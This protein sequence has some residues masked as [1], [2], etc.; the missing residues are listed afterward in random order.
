MPAGSDV[1]ELVRD[2][3]ML[4][5]GI[6]GNGAESGRKADLSA[7]AVPAD[8]LARPEGKS[9]GKAVKTRHTPS[10]RKAINAMCKSCIYDSSN[11]GGTW[12][13][14]VEACAVTR[15]ALYEVRPVSSSREPGE[16]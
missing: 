12:R 7:V 3:G 11:G 14:Q 9:A 15:C 16:E 8:V 10:L 5:A 4:D 6:G 2:G 1:M 13:Q